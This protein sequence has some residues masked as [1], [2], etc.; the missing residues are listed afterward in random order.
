MNAPEY[1]Y[2][3]KLL[4]IGDSAVG[5]TSLLLRYTD[6]AYSE[7]YISTIGVDFKIKTM[8]LDGKTVKLQIWDTAGQERFKTI[9]PT[10]YKGADGIIVVFDLTN[11]KS[12]DNVKKWLEEIEQYTSGKKVNKL[13]VGSKCDLLGTGK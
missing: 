6:E 5:K 4:I 13:L 7:H 12:Y 1:D 11:Q 9:T 8:E 10:Y 2:L 3:F